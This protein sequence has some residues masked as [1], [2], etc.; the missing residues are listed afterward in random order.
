MQSD[1]LRVVSE[2]GMRTWFRDE[3]INAQTT[4][5]LGLQLVVH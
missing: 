2:F 1:Q 3:F 4:Q 5:K